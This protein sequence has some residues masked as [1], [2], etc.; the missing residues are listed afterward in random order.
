MKI[1]ITAP[2]LETS[3]NVSGISSVVAQIIERS[4]HELFHFTTGRRDGEKI[5]IGWVFKQIFIAPRFFRQIR[6]EKIEIIHINTA[7]APLS[8]VRDAILTRTANF[9][10]RPVLLHLHG[11][12]FFTQKFDNFFLKRLTNTMLRRAEKIIVLSETEKDFIEQYWKNLDVRILENAVSTENFEKRE[13]KSSEKTIIFLGRLHEDK[14]LKEIIETCLILKKEGFEFQF[15]CFGAGDA[16]DFFVAE[17]NKILGEKFF[18]GGVVSGPEKQ[19]ELA[20]SDIFLLPSH[21]EGL[22]VALLEAMAAACV[23]VVS[24]IGSIGSVIEDNI[25][26]FLIES[27]NVP[28]IV[29]KLK[30]LLSEKTDLQNLQKRARKTIEE[31]FNLKYYIEKLECIYVTI[32]K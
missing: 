21:Y 11:G 12:K 17:M 23:P 10:K 15:R 7:L 22:P 5:N 1:L 2:S 4:R 29:E 3:E 30:P 32:L 6:R 8:I 19:K 18:Y 28:Q 14:G 13:N 27:Q 20:A 24:D 16:K 25:N 31:K 9:A 26:G